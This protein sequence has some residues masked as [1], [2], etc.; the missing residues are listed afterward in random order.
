MA[1]ETINEKIEKLQNGMAWLDSEDFKLE[2][3]SA[4]YKDLAKLATEIESDL[5]ELKNEINV[6]AEDF[7]K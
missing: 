3:A 4:K 7:S 5:N 1:K 6:I 2:E